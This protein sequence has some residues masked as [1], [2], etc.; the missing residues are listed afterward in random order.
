MEDLLIR[1]IVQGTWIGL[2]ASEVI[3]KKRGN[4]TL[5]SFVSLR[6]MPP[7]KL[8]FLIGYTEELLS[9]LLKTVVK[10]ELQT[11][12]KMEDIIYKFV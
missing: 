9:I 6:A 3:I 10:V 12:G 4:M 11:I 2:I 8:Y 5:V 1:R 7:A